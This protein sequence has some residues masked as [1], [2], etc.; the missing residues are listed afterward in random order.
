M[1]SVIIS[2]AVAAVAAGCHHPYPHYNTAYSYEAPYH[3]THN[4]SYYSLPSNA[5]VVYDGFESEDAFNNTHP[6]TY[7][8]FGEE[9]SPKFMHYSR[10]ADFYG[11]FW[12]TNFQRLM[13]K[14][15]SNIASGNSSNWKHRDIRYRF[16]A[17]GE[18]FYS[19]HN[20]RPCRHGVLYRENK[21][22][23]YSWDKIPSTFCKVGPNSEWLPMV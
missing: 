2:C 13:D 21:G 10:P 18:L 6:H 8:Q 14:K 7:Y 3:M 9:G 17:E 20:N 4:N 15:I 12:N 23:V 19:P 11:F 1:R 22:S 5:G 16:V